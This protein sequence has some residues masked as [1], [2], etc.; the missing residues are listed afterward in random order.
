MLIATGLKF[1]KH[2]LSLDLRNGMIVRSSFKYE[3]K[4]TTLALDILGI[5]GELVH[6]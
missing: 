3:G 2:F 1:F 4:Y 6:L 5:I